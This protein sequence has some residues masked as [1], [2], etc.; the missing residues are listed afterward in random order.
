MDQDKD[1]HMQAPEEIGLRMKHAEEMKAEKEKQ[2]LEATVEA[3]LAIGSTVLMGIA[4]YQRQKEEKRIAA[5]EETRE[6]YEI[7]WRNKKSE[8]ARAA[9]EKETI[10]SRGQEKEGKQ[11]EKNKRKEEEQE[12][13]KQIELSSAAEVQNY[14]KNDD[15]RLGSRAQ[16][17]TLTDISDW[18][19]SGDR[20]GPSLGVEAETGRKEMEKRMVTQG[21]VKPG[22][23]RQRRGEKQKRNESRR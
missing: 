12:A 3:S 19:T 2:E 5:E 18:H 15:A 13:K 6:F 16:Q 23:G 8:E 1:T 9:L 21:M 20:E 7:D 22:Q 10:E 11:E 4:N 17:G 14:T